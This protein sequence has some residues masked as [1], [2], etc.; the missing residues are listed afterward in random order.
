MF[1]TIKIMIILTLASGCWD[2]QGGSLAGEE[3]AGPKGN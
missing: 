2:V 3:V 1:K